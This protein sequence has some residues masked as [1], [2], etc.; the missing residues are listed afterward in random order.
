MGRSQDLRD[1]EVVVVGA[2]AILW[3]EVS[4]VVLSDGDDFETFRM[5]MTQVWVRLDG[6]W[7]CPAAHAGPRHV[8]P[9]LPRPGPI[10]SASLRRKRALMIAMPVSGRCDPQSTVMSRSPTSV[11]DMARFTPKVRRLLSDYLT[12]VVLLEIDALFADNDI[13]LGP[14]QHDPNDPSERRERMRRYLAT[15]DLNNPH[16]HAKLVAVYS[17]VMQEIGERAKHG[18][19]YYDLA[20]LKAKWLNTLTAAGFEIDQWSFVVT[21]PARPA[22]APSFAPAALAALADPSAI[23]DHLNRLGDT[24]DS[25]PRLAVSTA[26]ALI[27]STAKCVLSARKVPYTR[28]DS[29]PA[30]VTRAQESLGLAAKAASGEEPSLRRVL[31]SLVT[32]AQHVTEIR[33]QVGVDHGAES[34]PR[35]VRP[36]HA[37]LV[38][39][40]AQVWCQLMLETLG[41]PEAPWR[42]TTTTT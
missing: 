14:P 36:R 17:D 34:V 23:L 2:T 4:D 29:V 5:P 25:D 31:Q 8:H 9:L 24:V 22:S 1:P 3:A 11:R 42:Q 13:A 39:G 37:R 19:A 7:K 28:S 35:W 26:K 10:G 15:L 30:L 20:P 16:D 32:L 27:E 33:N 38:V 18:D 21:D 6:D 40:A 12:N 41:D